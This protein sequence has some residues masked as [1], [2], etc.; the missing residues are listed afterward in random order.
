MSD[1]ISI[2]GASGKTGRRV[3]ERLRAAGRMVRPLSRNTSPTFDWT[4]Q[5]GWQD[6]LA[7]SS[8]AYIA[9]APDI[10]L[11]GAVDDVAA[12][13]DV[14]LRAGARRLVMLSGRGEAE[15]VAAE[16][17]LKASGADWTIVRASWFCQNFSEGFFV[18]EVLGGRVHFPRLDTPEPFVDADDIADV[19]ANAFLDPHHIGQ[20]YEVTGPELLTFRQA[21]ETIG[22]ATGRSLETVPVSI[23]DYLAALRQAQVPEVYVGLL[24]YLIEEVLDGRNMS[25]ADGIERALGRPARSFRDYAEAAARAGAWPASKVA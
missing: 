25:T 12:F 11:P 15:A 19:V 2:T 23:P 1:L 10:A 3:A 22:A 5:A 20:L 8:A 21:L 16:E 13:I 9:Y 7:G 18:D 24:G 14:A 6:A 4:D 17:V